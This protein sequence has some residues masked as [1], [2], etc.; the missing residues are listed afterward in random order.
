MNTVPFD[1]SKSRFSESFYIPDDRAKELMFQLDIICHE[2][3]APTKDGSNRPPKKSFVLKKA[4]PLAESIP[5]LAFICYLAGV[6]TA[7][8]WPPEKNCA[9]AKVIGADELPEELKELLRHI[10]R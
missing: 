8:L 3:Q 9:G 6:R 1:D 5:E 10:A 2:A 7:K 4:L